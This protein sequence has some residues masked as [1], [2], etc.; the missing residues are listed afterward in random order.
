MKNKQ[1]ILLVGR[2]NLEKDSHLFTDVFDHLRTL[3]Y[4]IFYDP[5]D[6]IRHLVQHSFFTYVPKF[7]RQA[8][9]L[10]KIV[11]TT[12]IAFVFFKQGLF[13]SSYIKAFRTNPNDI[14][15]RMIALASQLKKFPVNTKI[16]LI[17][18]SA[19]AI[20]A[21]KVS[22]EFPIQQIICLGYP[23]KHPE[24]AE[25]TYRFEHLVDVNTPTLIIQGE[26][27]AYGGREILEK[28]PMNTSI[29]IIFEDLDHDFTLTEETRLRLIKLIK[30]RLM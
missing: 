21:T 24:K 10:R 6:V 18:R 19:G 16:T 27:D 25:E 28:Y 9:W 5:N 7:I 4:S 15:L 23:F 22:L 14:N 29:Q 2:E 12:V 11:R 8:A 26:R 30:E 13:S 20:L 1:I 17:G 3:P